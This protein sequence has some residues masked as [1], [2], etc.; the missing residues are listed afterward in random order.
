MNKEELGK[1]LSTND[2]E[3]LK[4]IPY[5]LQDLWE[6][7]GRPDIQ[8][9][10]I[11][12]LNLKN[13]KILDV[14]CGK[15]SSLIKILKYQTGKGVGVD[16]VEEFIE[17]AKNKSIEWEVDDRVEFRA[18]D[19]VETLKKEKNYDVVL[20]GVDSNVLG[21]IEECFERLKPALKNEGYIIAETIYPKVE[22]NDSIASQKE[23]QR[24][25][26][27]AGFVLLEEKIWDIEDVKFMNQEN[28]AKIVA[29][30]QE[31]IAKYPQEKAMFERYIHS[32]VEESKEL[33]DDFSCVSVLCQ[34]KS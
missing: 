27:K 17:E 22:M 30:A 24:Q 9:S 12:A 29:R 5:L 34:L 8:L 10:L 3:I 33:E 11:K 4:Y 14:G 26:Q 13:I 23:F 18:E 31:L 19:L 21:E 1:S 20:Y 32:Q 16:I 25:A 28:T 15:G 2:Q 7:G 6:L